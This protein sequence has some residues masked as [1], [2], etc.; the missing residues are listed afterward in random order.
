MKFL[1]IETLL[2]RNAAGGTNKDWKVGDLMIIKDH[3]SQFT[4]N[5][6]VGKNDETFGPRFPNMSEPYKKNLI[7]K[8][9][10]IAAAQNI[11]LFWVTSISSFFNFGGV[12][13]LILNTFIQ[14]SL[15][16]LLYYSFTAY[17]CAKFIGTAFFEFLA[18]S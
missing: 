16:Q 6:L 15:T 11:F 3:I 8:A 1:G 13:T 4:L 10:N 5:P 12:A 14:H 7:D 9:K 18:F 2:V 17:L